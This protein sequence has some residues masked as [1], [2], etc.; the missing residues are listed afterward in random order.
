MV[1]DCLPHAMAA[2]YA[3]ALVVCSIHKSSVD[4]SVRKPDGI[5]EA[6]VGV[7]RFPAKLLLLADGLA[8]LLGNVNGP[9][10]DKGGLGV[11]DGNPN[12]EGFGGKVIDTEVM[13]GRKAKGLLPPKVGVLYTRSESSCVII[14]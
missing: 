7:G 2:R 9:P 1:I 11:A 8:L 10:R 12:D 4:S 13:A 14:R 3:E 6:H 5:L